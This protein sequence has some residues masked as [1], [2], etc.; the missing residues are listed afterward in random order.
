MAEYRVICT[1]QEPPGRPHDHAV[2]V[3]LGTGDNPKAPP[4]KEWNLHEVLR[5]MASGHTFYTQGKSSDDKAVVG[6]YHCGVCG[7]QH[8]RTHP[9]AKSQNNLNALP[10]C[11]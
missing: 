8:L 9:D 11:P 2:I 6:T 4:K 10:D 5:A 1:R 7:Q 3:G